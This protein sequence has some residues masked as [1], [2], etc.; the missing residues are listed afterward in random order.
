MGMNQFQQNHGCS[1]P[2]T[3]TSKTQNT[4]SK[5]YSILKNTSFLMAGTLLQRVLSFFTSILITRYFGPERYGQFT[6][7]LALVTI[8]AVF[9]DFGL[10]TLFIRDVSRDRSIA[11]EYSGNVIVLKTVL[12]FVTFPAMLIYLKLLNYSHLVIEST[13]YFAVGNFIF[14]LTGIFESIFSAWKRL[15]YSAILNVLRALLLLVM[16]IVIVEFTGSLLG[17]VLCYFFSFV[18]VFVASLLILKRSFVLPSFKGVSI[19][20]LRNLIIKAFPYLMTSVVSIIL[21]KIDH[22]MISKMSGDVELG[23]YGA[24]YTLFEIIIAFFPMMIMRS[25]FPVLCEKYHTD[26]PAMIKLYNKLLKTLLFFGLPI[27]CG[28]AMLG[29]DFMV[30]LFGNDYASGGILMSVLG[31]AIWVFFITN[32]LGWTMVAINKQML[33]LYSGIM[34]MVA[35]V[36]INIFIIPVLGALGSAI[37]TLVCEM[38][39]L[40]FMSV[41]IRKTLKIRLDASNLKIIIATALMALSILLVKQFHISGRIVELCVTVPAAMV[42]YMVSAYA[43]KVIDFNELRLMIKSF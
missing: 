8:V 11:P 7:I 13:I 18:G 1:L 23:L 41:M 6:F 12:L 9:W 22:L 35:N 38:M 19:R 4:L 5:E 32:L 17:M 39:A 33:V 40:I 3:G 27:S 29:R 36:I 37:A 2:A 30:T 26:V 16:V 31:C 21:F 10:N 42:V 43:L 24:A 28:T 20:V 25:A 15:D 34:A 14:S